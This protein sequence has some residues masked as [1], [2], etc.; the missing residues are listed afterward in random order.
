MSIAFLVVTGILFYGLAMMKML[1]KS[2]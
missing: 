2:V 1:K